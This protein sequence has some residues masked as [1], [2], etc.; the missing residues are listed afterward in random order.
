MA[1]E[2]GAGTTERGTETAMSAGRRMRKPA[3][4]RMGKGI[5]LFLETRSHET[6]GERRARTPRQ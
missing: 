1:I 4:R 3:S 6:S 5:D 2:R